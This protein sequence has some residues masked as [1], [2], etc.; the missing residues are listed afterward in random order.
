MLRKILII[1]LLVLFSITS[2]SDLHKNDQ[3]QKIQALEKT[4]DSLEVVLIENH[5]SDALKLSNKFKNLSLSIKDYIVD[6]TL[7]IE[8]AEKIDLV[9]KANLSILPLDSLQNS[10]NIA[11]KAEKSQLMKLEKDI[12]NG[13]GERQHYHIYLQKEQSNVQLLRSQ[14][15]KWIDRKNEVLESYQRYFFELDTLLNKKE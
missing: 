12:E 14:V 8:F 13:Y 2:C 3:L 11:L 10:L 5:L 15:I 7:N 6:D 1:S 9:Q 4:I